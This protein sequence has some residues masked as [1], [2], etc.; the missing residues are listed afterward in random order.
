MVA[1][2]V[3]AIL[4]GVRGGNRSGSF[5]GDDSH[6]YIPPIS[7]NTKSAREEKRRQNIHI[8]APVCSTT[9]SKFALK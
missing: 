7:F 8:F 1:S 2:G 9:N 5:R 4:C 6:L 3:V